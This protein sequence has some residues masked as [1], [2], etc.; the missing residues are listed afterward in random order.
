M[1]RLHGCEVLVTHEWV[2]P[3]HQVSNLQLKTVVNTHGGLRFS[4]SW[5]RRWGL[6]DSL[7][8]VT[9]DGT[10]T[11]A[12]TE[13]RRFY[14]Q[15]SKIIHTPT[16]AVNGKGSYNSLSTDYCEAA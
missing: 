9:E 14:K 4:N 11:G 1:L 7:Q 8:F 3:I 5:K 12:L 13:I 15:G 6:S 2:S 16:V 10:D